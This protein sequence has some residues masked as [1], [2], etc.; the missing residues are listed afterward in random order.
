M[1]TRAKE[2]MG[3]ENREG[4]EENES[5]YIRNHTQQHHNDMESK[6]RAKVTKTNND[7]FNRQCKSR[8]LIMRSDRE[9]LYT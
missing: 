7:S 6:V 5:C 1:Y 2:E 4:K 3:S 8:V 9:M